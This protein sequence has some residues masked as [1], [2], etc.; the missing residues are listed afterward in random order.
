MRVYEEVVRSR[1]KRW[2]EVRESEE[3]LE[4]GRGSKVLKSKSPKV[5]GSIFKYDLDS[6]EIPSFLQCVR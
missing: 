3:V 2:E 1:S 6:K 5:P 4:E